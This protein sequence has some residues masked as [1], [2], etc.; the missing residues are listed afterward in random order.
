MLSVAIAPN[1]VLTGSDIDCV[2]IKCWLDV[3][4]AGD[5]ML[6]S[7]DCGTLRKL[8][9]EAQPATRRRSADPL[10]HGPGRVCDLPPLL[11]GGDG[12]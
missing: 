7:D 11:P 5:A 3:D 12:F 6:A 1:M 8:K 10:R 9:R 4:L 2:S